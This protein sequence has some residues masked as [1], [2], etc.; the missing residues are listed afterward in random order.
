MSP[1]S[2]KEIR[3]GMSF[4]RNHLEESKRIIDAIDVT[5]VDRMADM[6]AALRAG[7]GRLF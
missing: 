4:S 6:L 2:G 3:G 1:A 7:G 5:V